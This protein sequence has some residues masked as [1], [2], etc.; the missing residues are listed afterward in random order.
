MLN[1]RGGKRVYV[2]QNVHSYPSFSNSLLR[3]Y[4]LPNYHT[5]QEGTVVSAANEEKLRAD[6]SIQVLPVG[7]ERF[8][9]PELY[10]HPSDLGLNQAGVHE[11]VEQ[12]IADCPPEA[13]RML[14]SN[15]LLTGG[16]SQTEGLIDRL[17]KELGGRYSVRRTEQDP[18]ETPLLGAMKHYGGGGEGHKGRSISKAEYEEEGADRLV[19][20]S[21]R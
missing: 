1:A 9:V 20:Q 10:F 14:E 6:E 7:N 4:A 15:V 17:R 18:M 13:Q 3:H 16:N 19:S 21:Q 11:A 12:A 2:H 5:L 8:V